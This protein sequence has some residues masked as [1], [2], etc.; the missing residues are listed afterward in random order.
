MNAVD[1][2]PSPL[3][4]RLIDAVVGGDLLDLGPDGRIDPSIMRS[5]GQDRTIRASI[6]RRIVMGRLATDPD[7][8]GLQL[9]GVRIAGRIDLR[10]V[11]SDMWIELQECHV[12]DGLDLRAANLR[13]LDLTG[14][15]VGHAPELGRPAVDADDMTIHLLRLDR[16]SVTADTTLG[17]VVL[18]GARIGGRLDCAWARIANTH[19]PAIDAVNLR[20]DGDADFRRLAATCAGT[21]GAL[22]LRDA[23]IAGDVDCSGAQLTNTVGAALDANGMH[24]DGETLFGSSFAATSGCNDGTVQLI[25]ARIDKQL[26]CREGLVENLVGPAI[27]ADGLHIDGNFL[28]RG[29]FNV[30]SACPSG[31]IRLLGAF[32]GGQLDCPGAQV[33]NTS[34]PAIHAEG[35]RVEGDVYLNQGFAATGAT[36]YGAVRLLGADIGGHL[37]C[38]GATLTNASGPALDGNL[39]RIG[40]DVYLS[41]GFAATGSDEFGAIVLRGARIGGRVFFGT[42]RIHNTAGAAFDGTG[43]HE[44]FPS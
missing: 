24:V 5:W 29:R 13:A 39:M 18:S 27:H 9:R 11:T 7:P 20:L 25:N 37:M 14:S 36:H 33:S 10:N 2:Q 12:P 31:G 30:R 35:I 8:H 38:D 44:P 3:E 1:D 34:G 19:G 17:A 28:L 21:Y 26:T 16:I 4:R 23:R 32:V 42:G 41:G 15:L 40:R 6:I 22:R 43:M